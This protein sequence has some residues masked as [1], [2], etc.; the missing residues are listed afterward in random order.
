MK[1]Y[2][3]LKLKQTTLAISGYKHQIAKS[4]LMKCKNIDIIEYVREEI[5]RKKK[6]NKKV[7][8]ISKF[9]PR[10]PHP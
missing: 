3:Y 9:G 2:I 5:E 4:E 10:V 7:F 6:N 1:L 8:W